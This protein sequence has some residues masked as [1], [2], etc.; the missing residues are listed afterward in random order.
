MSL[1]HPFR[2]PVI[3]PVKRIRKG[4]VHRATRK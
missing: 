3:R 2:L 4:A 1:F